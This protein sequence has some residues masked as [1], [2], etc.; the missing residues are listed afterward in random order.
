MIL[1]HN[2]IS[3]DSSYK[4]FNSLGHAIRHFEH[5]KVTASLELLRTVPR[6]VCSESLLGRQIARIIRLRIEM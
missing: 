2:F 1:N 5:W 4:T 6:M 3:D